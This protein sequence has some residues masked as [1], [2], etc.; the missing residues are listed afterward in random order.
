MTNLIDYNELASFIAVIESGSYAEASRVLGVPANTLSRRVQSLESALGV[1]LMQ[2]STHQMAVTPAGR[3][4]FDHCKD[5][6][7]TIASASRKLAAQTKR[8]AGTLRVAA[9][10]DFFDFFDAAWLEEF[11]TLY[12]DLRLELLLSDSPA[13]MLAERI[14][15]ALRRGHLPSSALVAKRLASNDHVL[16]ASSAYLRT[17]GKPTSIADLEDHHCIIAPATDGK[18]R[19][20]LQSPAGIEEVV[21]QGRIGADNRQ[22]M[23]SAALGG[24]GIALVPDSLVRADL[25]TGRLQRVLHGVYRDGGGLHAVFVSGGHIPLAASLFAAFVSDKLRADQDSSALLLR[26]A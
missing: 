14:D 24:L 9:P 12:K 8:T 2:R 10:V 11:M 23:R 3:L 4:L 5:A 18:N 1:R 22:A 7:A 26:A 25:A 6:T 20:R 17:H 19:W 16:V 15:V 21:V 13:N